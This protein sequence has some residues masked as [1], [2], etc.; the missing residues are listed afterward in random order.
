MNDYKQNIFL[1]KIKEKIEIGEYDQYLNLPFQSRKLLIDSIKNKLS[2]KISSGGTPVLNDAEIKEC[3][4]DTKETAE[5]TIKIFVKTGIII[6]TEEGY[7]TSK[8]GRKLINEVIKF[9]F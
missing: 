1:S 2:K 6:K 9:N 4:L 3:I 7:E 5:N 8:L